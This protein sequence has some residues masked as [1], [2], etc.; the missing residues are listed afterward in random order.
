MSMS[1]KILFVMGIMEALSGKKDLPPRATPANPG[2]FDA[3][4]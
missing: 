3:Q 1:D 2:G 4:K